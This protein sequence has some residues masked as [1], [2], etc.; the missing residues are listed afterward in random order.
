ME[1]FHLGKNHVLETSLKGRTLLNNPI[2]NKG[3]A[4]SKEERTTFGLNGLLPP[5]MET[6]QTQEA[7]AYDAYKRKKTDMGRHVYLREL[8]DRNETLFYRLLT[9]HISE[10]LPMVY[11]PVVG[12]ACTRFHEIYRQSRGLFISYP[13]REKM[14]EIIGNIDL[15]DVKVIVV[16]DGERILGLGDQ[17][18]G[19]MGIPIGK[20]SLYTACGGLFPAY[21]LPIILDTGTDN[22]ERLKDPLYLGWRHRRIRGKEYDDFVDRFVQ[23]ILKRYPNVLLQWEDFAKDNARTLLDRYQNKL[24]TFNDDIQGTASVTLAGLLAAF[25]ANQDSIEEQQIVIYGGGSAG[26]GIADQIVLALTHHGLSKQEACRHIWMIDR[27]GLLH[28]GMKDLAPFQ[29]PYAQPKEAVSSIG[30]DASKDILLEQVIE[31]VHPHALI[32]VSGSPGVFT[33]KAIRLMAKYVSRPIL[34]PLSNPDTRCEAKP[35]DLIEWTDGKALI[36]TGTQFPDVSYKGK[37]IRID[38]CN[39]Y[40]IFPAMG[41]SVLASKAKRVTSNMFYAAAEG[42]AALSPVLKN[43]QANLFPRADQVRDVAKKLSLQIALQAQK[44]GVAPSMSMEELQKSVNEVFWE[45][46]YFPLLIPNPEK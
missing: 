27:H 43:P 24:C 29:I 36:A 37:T 35:S 44:D 46:A 16:S 5:E 23:A 2:L 42:L 12:E 34:F 14:D 10:M 28:T 20:I 30:M 3:T 6:I 25:K 13:E 15:P 21:G 45:P 41:L 32:G 11:T 9:H 7:R 1:F 22:E 18:V 39:N 17:G 31:H 19:G 4:F 8:Q 33:E 40:Y 26:T 38:Q